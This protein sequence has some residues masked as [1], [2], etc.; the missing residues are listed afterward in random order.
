MNKRIFRKKK[1]SI[2]ESNRVIQI[3]SSHGP[4][5]YHVGDKPNT[6]ICDYMD[7][8]DYKC[9]VEKPEDELKTNLDTYN[10]S[11]LLLYMFKSKSKVI[12]HLL[13]KLSGIFLFT[14]TIL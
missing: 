4:M 9:I 11:F 5:E 1:M 10:K 14:T 8:C 7:T 13:S 3:Q 2:I 12:S 6:A